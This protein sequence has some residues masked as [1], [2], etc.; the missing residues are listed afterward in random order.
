VDQPELRLQFGADRV[1]DD[2]TGALGGV[3]GE[4]G[5]LGAGG[6]KEEDGA[7]QAA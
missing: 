7:D 4:P 2:A 1:A 3:G 6:E 5:V